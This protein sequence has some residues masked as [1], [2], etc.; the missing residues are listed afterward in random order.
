MSITKASELEGMK[1]VSEVVATTLR[2]MREHA[3]VGM[4]TK[5][6]DNFGG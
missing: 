3:K 6:L 4:S 2:L 1:R 5:E